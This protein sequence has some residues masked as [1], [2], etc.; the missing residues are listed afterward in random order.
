[1]P[2]TCALTA[3]LAKK[4]VLMEEFGGCTAPP[5]KKS[6]DWTWMG[7]GRVHR[8]FMAAEE[9]WAEYFTQVLPKLVEVGAMGALTWCHADYHPSLW[10]KPPC[11]GSRHE[12]HFGLVRPDGS[13]K[14]YAQVIKDFAATKPQ[15]IQA[16]KKITL[17][18]SAAEYYK[19]TLQKIYGL[20]DWWLG[21]A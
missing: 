6:F 1:V 10:D 2:Y 16:V 8:Q 14:P 17:P 12:R 4:P 11:S 19:N 21:Q 18:Y 7:Y 13:L 15:V 20:Y 9:T 3:V 5:G